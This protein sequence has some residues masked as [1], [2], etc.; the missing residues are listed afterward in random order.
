MCSKKEIRQ[1][2]KQQVLSLSA[3]ER[4]QLS[5][6]ALARLKQHPRYQTASV[7][8]LFSSLSDEVITHELIDTESKS[9]T[10]LLPVVVGNDIELRIYQGAETMKRGAFGISEPQ[11]KTFREFEKIDVIIVPGV[12]FDVNCNRLG[13]GKGYYD[14]FLGQFALRH[15]FKIGLCFPFQVLEELP[16][17]AHD[18]KMDAVI[19]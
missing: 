9:K 6:D 13:R 5:A 2:I 1:R 15:V 7:V 16:T 14:R 3:A 12:A 8:A 19:S 10:V 4:Q 18:V 17:Q 11:G